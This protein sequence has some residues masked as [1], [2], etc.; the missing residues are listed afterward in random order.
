V[1][2]NV[3]LTG[4]PLAG[5]TVIRSSRAVSF[6]SMFAS[7]STRFGATSTPMTF[8]S[9]ALPSSP[10]RKRLI[11]LDTSFFGLR[12]LSWTRSSPASVR[13]LAS[14]RSLS[15]FAAETFGHFSGEPFHDP[16]RYSLP[17]MDMPT[18]LP[19]SSRNS[20][21]PSMKGLRPRSRITPRVTGPRRTV[22]VSPRRE[23]RIA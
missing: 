18:H 2:R 12:K 11:R 3:P 21:P 4:L 10:R 7:T 17:V 8:C 13:R 15:I 22:H 19:S 23:R 9:V 6:G 14:A 1:C 16:S 20:P 5:W